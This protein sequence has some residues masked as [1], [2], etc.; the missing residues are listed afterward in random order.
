MVKKYCYECQE[1]I[2]EGEECLWCE[3]CEAV[4]HID[5]EKE[6]TE[7]HKPT[8]LEGKVEDGVFKEI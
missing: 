6:H 4:F 5:C 3:Q 2:V 8:Y 1:L 7:R